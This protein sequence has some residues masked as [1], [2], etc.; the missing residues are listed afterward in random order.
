MNSNSSLRPLFIFRA[1]KASTME[2][3]ANVREFLDILSDNLHDRAK[4][5]FDVMLKMKKQE[6]PY[7]NEL[8]CWD[9]PYFTHKARTQMLNVANSDFSPYFSLGACMEGL[10]MLCQELY[11]ITLKYEEMLPG[12]YQ[13]FSNPNFYHLLH[14]IKL[15][16]FHEI[17]L[18]FRI[19]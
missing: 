10:N 4:M 2:S 9:T 3:S 14:H 13:V 18:L 15:S 7:L 8:M 11:G 6:T 17:K 19:L 16:C 5:D 1:I 12:Y